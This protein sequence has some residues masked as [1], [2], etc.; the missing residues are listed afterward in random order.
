[1]IVDDLVAAFAALEGYWDV[2]S[3]PKLANN[4]MAL[5]YAGQDGALPQTYPPNA[6]V[7]AKFA[8]PAHGWVA[9]YRQIFAWAQEGLS[10]RQM[11]LRQCPTDLAYLSKLLAFLPGPP[12]PDM[13]VS[14]LIPLPGAK[15]S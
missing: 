4:P 13:P 7:F 3:I 1:M 15:P 2:L 9:A 10:I 6:L 5:I 12:C 14:E 8:T 11:C